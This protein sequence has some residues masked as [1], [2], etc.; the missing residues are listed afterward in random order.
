MEIPF[1]SGQETDWPWPSQLV[2]IIGAPEASPDPEHC[3]GP[4]HPGRGTRGL[5]SCLVR[6]FP[7]VTENPGSPAG[8]TQVESALSLP[9]WGSQGSRE[10]VVLPDKYLGGILSLQQTTGR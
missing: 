9:A 3:F 5:Q 6:A 1:F 2:D 8:R 10:A 4:W 7:T